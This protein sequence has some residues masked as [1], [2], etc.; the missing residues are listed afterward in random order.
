LEKDWGCKTLSDALIAHEMVHVE[1]CMQAYEQ[2]EET[3]QKILSNP[4]NIAE[5]ELQAWT[6]HRDMIAEQI[7]NIIR[8]KGCGWQPT[9]G[10]KNDMNAIP[11]IKQSI[12]MQKRGYKAVEALSK[13]Q[14]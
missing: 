8:N 10:Q 2:G 9:K 4:A 6:R 3:A 14:P 12:D 11:S 13:G 7:R 5:S 1:H